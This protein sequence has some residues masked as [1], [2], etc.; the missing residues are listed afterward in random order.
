MYC[1]HLI[2]FF[3]F[4]LIRIG[5]LGTTYRLERVCSSNRRLLTLSTGARCF[6]WATLILNNTV[7]T[8][9][10]TYSFTAGLGLN[11]HHGIFRVLH[12]RWSEISTLDFAAWFL[13]CQPKSV[14]KFHPEDL[15]GSKWM[16]KTEMGCVPYVNVPGLHNYTKKR[17]GD[18][19]SVLRNK[20]VIKTHDQTRHLMMLQSVEVA[21]GDL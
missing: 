4:V 1:T 14:T 6:C 17:L 5:R 13:T 19:E 3:F 9:N 20:M 21:G 2:H 7:S 16:L 12:T 18:V 8:S 10:I 11:S 15:S